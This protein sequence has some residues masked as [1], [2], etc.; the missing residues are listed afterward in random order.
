REGVYIEK[1][2]GRLA[3]IAYSRIGRRLPVH[4]TAIGK[5]LIAWLGE[6]E[7]N[8]LLEGYQYTA[9]T[10]ATLASREALLA[11][12]AQ[13]REQGYA[14]DSEENEQGVRCVA[15]PVWNHES[16]VIAALSLSTL[17]SRVDDAELANF[18]EQLQQAGLQ[19]SRALG[20][21]A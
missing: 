2:E 11:A 15:V 6:A 7:L 18:R 8:A 14:L 5:V 20:Y 3:A 1:I 4:A 17:T 19:L 9:F 12:L 10:P 13:T 16:R 21:P